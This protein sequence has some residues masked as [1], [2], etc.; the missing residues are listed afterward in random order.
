MRRVF[1]EK[2]G[3]SELE[4]TRKFDSELFSSSEIVKTLN[5]EKIEYDGRFGLGFLEF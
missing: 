5:N 1:R 2:T 4:L 3:V